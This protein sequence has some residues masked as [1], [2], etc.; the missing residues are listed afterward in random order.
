MGRVLAI[1]QP[2]YLPWL[3]YFHK[4]AHCDVFVFLDNVQYEKGGFT[5]RNKIKT[6]Q[7]PRWLTVAVSTSGNYRQAVKDVR[8][9]DTALWGAQHWGALQTSYANA[10]CFGESAPRFKAIYAK[11]W[12]RLADLNEALI[13]ATCSMLG[14]GGVEFRKASSMNV[15]GAKSDLL[16][17]IC[18]E[19]AAD[20]YLTGTGASRAYLQEEP[21]RRAG[22]KVA[23]D[24]FAHP[25]Y[26]Q[27]WGKFCPNM[28]VVDLVFNEGAGS[29]GIIEANCRQRGS[30]DL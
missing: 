25:T 13:I 30:H 26:G 15:S 5:N 1:H 14:I 3:G 4:I 11:P 20:T 10:R 21:F 19:V 8:I 24:E 29:L 22:V 9:S 2:N 27:L 7:G 17:Q 16:A 23:F 28:S 6:S 18:R 12:E